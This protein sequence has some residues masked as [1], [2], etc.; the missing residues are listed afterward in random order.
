MKSIG[1]IACILSVLFLA[2]CASS[3]GPSVADSGPTGLRADGDDVNL[4]QS[5]L[6]N[7]EKVG[8]LFNLP[9]AL[10]NMY[11][12]RKIDFKTGEHY[13]AQKRTTPVEWRFVFTY[14]GSEPS[15]RRMAKAFLLFALESHFSQRLPITD[16]EKDTLADY[17]SYNLAGMVAPPVAEPYSLW[18]TL[19]MEGVEAP[20]GE[21]QEG[22]KVLIAMRT[23]GYKGA[24][25]T[26]GDYGHATLGVRTM[27]GDPDDDFIINPGAITPDDYE[28]SVKGALFGDENVPNAVEIFNF[29]DWLEP[30]STVRFLDIDYR[31]LRVAPEQMRALELIREETDKMNWGNFKMLANNCANGAVDIYNLLRRID[32]AEPE[33]KK[34]GKLTVPAD[35]IEYATRSFT[36]AGQTVIPSDAP[37]PDLDK[38]PGATYDPLPDRSASKV[39]RA[40]VELEEQV[41]A[42]N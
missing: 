5:S 7:G 38:T 8:E 27:G 30:Q 31:I 29:W 6:V 1:S 10:Q 35:A 15:V 22:E 20:T 23:F 2:G 26:V 16:E 41:L 14:P 21:I 18:W 25:F 34:L 24:G 33:T 3:P 42:D 12:D 4:P 37:P 19:R 32:L 39:Y 9:P 36:L 13:S 17:G 40:A 11:G 28:G